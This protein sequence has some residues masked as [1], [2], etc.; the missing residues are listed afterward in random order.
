MKP[1]SN[2]KIR[3]FNAP[4]IDGLTSIRFS[5][6]CKKLKKYNDEKIVERLSK[7]IHEAVLSDIPYEPELC[8]AFNVDKNKN[9]DI[10]CI[11]Q[12]YIRQKQDILRIIKTALLK[13]EFIGGDFIET[14]LENHSDLNTWINKQKTPRKSPISCISTPHIGLALKRFVSKYRR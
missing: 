9:I 5:M 4:C 8:T 2:K 3:Y 6:S 12:D 7:Q 11:V 13:N 1:Y 10:Y 14:T